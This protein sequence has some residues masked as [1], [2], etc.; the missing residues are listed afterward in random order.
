MN[1]HWPD[2]TYA[3]SP[4]KEHAGNPFIESLPP[5][6]S[7]RAFTKQATFHPA[8][9]PDERQLPRE[10]RR[11]LIKRLD[12][13]RVPAT[14]I[15]RAHNKLDVELRSGYVDRDPRLPEMRARMYG[16][17]RFEEMTVCRPPN[18]LLMTG[19]SGVGKTTLLESILGAYPQVIV[20]HGIMPGIG[21][22]CQVVYIKVDCPQDASI[23]GLCSAVFYAI[24]QLLG[25]TY[26]REWSHSHC[27]IDDFLQCLYQIINNF[28]L[29]CLVLDELQHL[30]AAKAGGQARMLNLLVNLINGVGIPL[31]LVGT[32]AL[33]GIVEQQMRNARRAVGVGTVGLYRFQRK[34]PMWLLFVRHLWNCQWVKNPVSLTEEIEEVLYDC[35]QGLRNGLVKLCIAAQT[36]AL[37]DESETVTEVTLRTTY[38]REFKPMHQA[39]N[40][41]RAGYRDDDPIFDDLLKAVAPANHQL[42]TT[43]THVPQNAAVETSR[44]SSRS[45]RRKPVNPAACDRPTGLAIGQH[46]YSSVDLDLRN[47]AG[48]AYDTMWELEVIDRNASVVSPS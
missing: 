36:A 27:T 5:I 45:S 38:D 15:I 13:L 24:D 42:I 47:I 35:T 40:H 7:D 4:I 10:L 28:H 22:Q 17:Y 37:D 2:A 39:M 41:L 12:T 1:M 11:H 26:L 20:H 9:D 33:D 46:P 23:R 32:W 30:S 18:C 16:S 21:Q 3:P 6:L 48:C 19:L 25:T 8:C 43:A 29:G 31:V 14:E 34:D 44:T